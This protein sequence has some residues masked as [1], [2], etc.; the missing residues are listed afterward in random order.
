MDYDQIEG[1]LLSGFLRD[2]QLFTIA[3][4]EG[5]HAD[6]IATPTA[7]RLVKALFDLYGRNAIVDD[8]AVRAYLDDHGLFSPEMERYLAAAL[9]RTPPNAG[10]VVSYLDL[11]KARESRELL[12]KVYDDLGTFLH[13]GGDRPQDIV[14]VTTDAVGRLMEIQKR[15]IR[16]QVAPVSTA[17]GELTEYAERADPVRQLG[18]A[19]RPFDR[20]NE[21]LSGL[22]RGFYY[23]LAGAPRRGKTNFALELATSVATNHRIPVL[24]Y[25]WEQTRRVLGARL[26][27]R[28]TGLNP[29]WILSGA[30]PDGRSIAPKLR[31]AQTRIS[32]Y[33]PFLYVVEAGRQHTLDRVRGHAYNLMQEFETNDVVIFF[34]YLQ[35]I[36]LS[37]YVDDQ[38]AR[39]DF[40][41]TALAE[42]SLELNCP[43]FAISP[44]DKEGCRLDERP[45][46]EAEEFNVYNRPTMHHSMGSG[47]LEYDL[48]V[49]M[50]MAKDWKA[51]HDL[52]Q[53][54][55]S[56][57]RSEGTDPALMPKVDIINL[58][59][60]KNRDAPETAAYIVQYAF[61][62]TLNKFLEVDY[63]LEK[64]YR[65]D[66][67]AFAKTQEIYNYLR[68]GGYIP[69]REVA[70]KA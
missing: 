57:A 3:L 41:S 10:Q 46:D 33:S 49:A 27:A 7:K 12:E 8:M 69:T 40:I 24:Y 38:R 11:L 17:F 44:L 13:K 20:L 28:E 29:T 30:D 42:M 53:L 45:A 35:K 36:P 6:L 34:D 63:K 2:R 1:A 52:F 39:T 62:V 14:Q 21:V 18:F 54:L 68:E 32:R 43:I 59:V 70:P 56:K 23:G 60:D 9:T 5:F 47:D 37:E 67:H 66:F 16:K 50:V 4:N 48:D 31:D 61:F 65:P 22:R 51:T 64:E 26:M 19:I 55:E 15:R 58:F 25:T